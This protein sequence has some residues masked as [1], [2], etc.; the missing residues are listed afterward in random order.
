MASVTIQDDCLAPEG[1]MTLK[2]NGPIP[3]K[4]YYVTIT[5]MRK[6]WEVEAKDYWEREFRWD[7][8]SDPRSFFVKAYVHKGIDRFTSV[9]IEVILEG[10]Q[11]ADSNKPGS[12]LIKIGGV[13]TTKFGGGSVLQ[14]ARNPIYA[15]L[16]WLYNHLFYR[17]QRRD[18][19]EIWCKRRLYE[20]KRMY[21]EFLGIT[22]SE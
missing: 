17:K 15:G 22:E 1:Y 12:L 10:K 9:T 11:P 2:Y 14:D 19:L 3:F 13:L 4:A 21:Q 20:L 6:I 8:T 5:F 7:N 18:Y 16:I